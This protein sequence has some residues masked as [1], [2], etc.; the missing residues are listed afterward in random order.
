M[1]R[2]DRL[3]KEGDIMDAERFE[4]NP[5]LSPDEN[6]DWEA[7]AAFNGCPVRYKD[8]VI[9][10]Y[11]ALSI[12]FEYCGFK[13]DLS[14]I[15]CAESKNG[16]NF[17]DR[18]Q[19]VEPEYDWEKFGCEDPRATKVD[20]RYFIF[21]TAL[22][23]YPP[24]AEG[25]KVAVAIT[26]DFHTIEE[27]HTVTTFN[28]KAMALFP[29]KI[30]G[31][32]AA[33]LTV[34]TDKPPAEIGIAL[35]DYESQM[36]S[37]EYW[38]IW[39]SNLKNNI[40]QLKRNEK[41][42][43]EV[44][45][46]PIKTKHGWLLVYSHIQNYNAPNTI[47]G[48]E[49]V[50]LDINN[51]MKIIGRTA[52]PIIVPEKYYEK[53]GVIPNITFPSGALL[54]G[55]NLR[56]YYGAS[57]TTCCVAS[58]RLEEL[59]DTMLSRKPAPQTECR[60]HLKSPDSNPLNES[61]CDLCQ[62]KAHLERSNT[63][64]LMV[65]IEEH[66]WESKYTLNTGAI[67]LGGK[68]HLLYRA[69][70]DDETS[71]LGYAS[72]RDG[73]HLDERLES[74]VYLPREDFEKKKKPGFSGC[75][76]PRLTQIGDRIYMCYT[77]F[78]GEIPRIAFTSIN[79]D[80]FL[81]RKWDAWE[82]PKRIS[83]PGIPDKNCCMFPE[84]ILDKYVFL[85]RMGNCIWI[86]YVD[87]LNFKDRWLGGNILF[88]IRENSWDS[89]KIGIGGVPIKTQYGWLLIYHSLSKHDNKYRLGA[90]LMDFN[91]PR[92]VV[93]RLPYPILEPDPAFDKIKGIYRPGTVFSCGSVVAGNNLFVY[94][95]EADY[96]VC[97][98][99]TKLDKLM[100][101]LEKIMLSL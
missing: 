5:I 1:W 13:L 86:D 74:P 78:N 60:A 15:G 59:I 32:F 87:D 34:N 55:D 38:N 85:H 17:H 79:V 26:R 97:V 67:Y 9:M 96:A 19:L 20:D 81:N 89:L 92:K 72:S 12:P 95:G 36:W 48:I 80:D 29:E 33:V 62:M 40:I 8:R 52:E 66:S 75:E 61:L 6:N 82:K 41:D 50:L 45:A 25:I 94:Y 11:R 71:V 57:D 10:P 31:K 23:N 56:I 64:P 30:N 44:G 37:K 77:A 101:C 53:H 43:I 51:P 46:P 4:G 14:S 90:A 63:N 93:A 35:F 98:A 3:D 83:P 91:N 54:D 18:W 16:L 42:H 7:K 49:A 24:N 22:S 69:M 70:G 28:S 58:I 84:K 100:E 47:F 27:K 99:S 76:D 73:F 88:T 39:Y 2:I 21:Y 68:V 65:P